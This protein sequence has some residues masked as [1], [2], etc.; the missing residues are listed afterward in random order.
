MKIEQNKNLKEFSTYK[1]GGVA[2]YFCTARS[3]IDLQE[4]CAWAE[5]KK[6]KFLVLGG[7]S[8]LL[9]NDGEIDAL[10][11]K[12]ENTE[13]KAQSERI[14]AQAGALLSSLVLSATSNTLTG[15]EWAAG[16]PGTVGGAVRGNA[17]CFGS[18]IKAVIETVKIF[19]TKKKKIIIFSN[20]DCDFTYRSSVIKKNPELLII[21]AIFKLQRGRLDEIKE[22]VDFILDRRNGAYPRLPSAGSV[23]KSLYLDEIKPQNQILHKKYEESDIARNGKIGAW[24]LIKELGLQGHIIGGAKVSL[25]HANFIVNTGKA[26]SQDV[27]DLINYVKN[28][29]KLKLGIDLEE[30]IVYFGF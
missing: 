11:I 6:K 21:E 12:M 20:K 18:D 30:E 25:E 13:I 8:N 14:V 15:M 23:F 22:K 7:G 24:R 16:V 28:N 3:E 19:D 26:S 4:A 27:I 10:V 29:V 5:E 17:G 1:I 2:K 9:I